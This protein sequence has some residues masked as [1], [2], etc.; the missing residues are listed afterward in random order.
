MSIHLNMLCRFWTY[1][2]NTILKEIKY[3]TIKVWIIFSL[4]E[5]DSLVHPHWPGTPPWT[6]L[7]EASLRPRLW[8]SS[9]SATW[10]CV[11]VQLGR[12][13]TAEDR[14]PRPHFLSIGILF[15]TDSNGNVSMPKEKSTLGLLSA[16]KKMKTARSLTKAKVILTQFLLFFLF[17]KNICMLPI[18]SI[19]AEA[20]GNFSRTWLNFWLFLQSLVLMVCLINGGRRLGFI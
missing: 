7:A 20:R 15:T 9:C 19:L 13:A 3:V 17:K 12:I 1:T 14:G 5:V 10:G 4:S 2:I 18:K 11:I 6:P 16:F 8:F